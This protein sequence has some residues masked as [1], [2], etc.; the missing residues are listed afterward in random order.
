MQRK[1]LKR[2]EWNFSIRPGR[3]ASWLTRRNGGSDT[4]EAGLNIDLVQVGA[5]AVLF[6]LVAGL[7][8]AASQFA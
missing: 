7:V 2:F 3:I 4:F 8:W 5:Y 6:L 1:T